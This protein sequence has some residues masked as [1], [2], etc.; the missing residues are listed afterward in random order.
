MCRAEQSCCARPTQVDAT[1][2]PD[3]NR[4][5]CCAPA[6][7]IFGEFGKCSKGETGK[8][9]WIF[10]IASSQKCA[11]CGCLAL[12]DFRARSL[13]QSQWRSTPAYLGRYIRA[14]CRASSSS[15]HYAFSGVWSLAPPL[16]LRGRAGVFLRRAAPPHR[17]SL[18]RPL[19][20]R[21]EFLSL[22]RRSCPRRVSTAGLGSSRLPLRPGLLGL[23]FLGEYDFWGCPADAGRRMTAGRRRP[24]PRGGTST[25]RMVRYFILF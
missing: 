21:F 22:L 9:C 1:D 24:S 19:L 8:S 11:S 3:P 25:A 6:M 16:R 18:G 10:E 4:A 20:P 14:F 2:L 13:L 7:K 15:V 23:R 5:R 12:S 17:P